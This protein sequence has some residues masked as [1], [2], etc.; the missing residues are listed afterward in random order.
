MR[1]RKPLPTRLKVL[2]GN[3][4]KR[5]LNQSEPPNVDGGRKC[6]SHLKG[7]ARKEFNRMVEVLE[8]MGMMS[9]AFAPAIA[10]YATAYACHVDALK[11][12]AKTG[13]APVIKTKDGNFI[14][15]PLLGVINRSRDDMR[16]WLIEFG[17][18][19]SS[20]SRVTNDTDDSLDPAAE[21]I[22]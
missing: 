2:H 9:A 20:R 12:Y 8:K 19:P 14:Q 4:G 7:D 11:L 3:P 21:F 1:G 10:A 5:Q 18:T 16:K 22:A 13:S 15:N 17:M 6:P